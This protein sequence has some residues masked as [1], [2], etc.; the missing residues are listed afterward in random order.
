MGFFDFVVLVVD[1]LFGWFLLIV[2]CMLLS[3][4]RFIFCFDFVFVGGLL[5]VAAVFGCVVFACFG[6]L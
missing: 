1:L 2:L 3:S 5:F 6:L 4:Y